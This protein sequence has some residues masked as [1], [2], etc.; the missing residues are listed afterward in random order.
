MK[1]SVSTWAFNDKSRKEA[2]ERVASFGVAGIEVIAHQPCFHVD[3]GFSDEQVE[4]VK[5]LLTAHGLEISAISPSTEFL[6]FDEQGMRAQLDHMRQVVDLSCRVG[7]G[8]RS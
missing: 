5:G 6:Q 8:S 1:P 2:F 3:V 7:G 4:Y